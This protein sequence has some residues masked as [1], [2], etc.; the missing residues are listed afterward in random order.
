ME[1]SPLLHALCRPLRLART[2]L[3]AS[4]RKTWT[5]APGLRT[6]RR[7]A[8]YLDG[9][10][11]RV[12]ATHRETSMPYEIARLSDG[13]V[14]HA[15]TIG[16][17][18]ANARLLDGCLYAGRL[19]YVTSDKRPAYL[20]LRGVEARELGVLS[21]SYIG[22]RYFGHWMTDDSTL[23]RAARRI[24]PPIAGVRPS[25]VHREGYER[26]LDL[27][28]DFVERARFDELVVIDDHGM[29]PDRVARLREL[30][31]CFAPYRA[32]QPATGVY[33]RH[34]K[35]GEPRHLQGEAEVEACLARRGF[36]SIEPE[37][38]TPEQVVR[39]LSGASTVV[40]LESS[41]MAPGI[42]ALADGGA[43]LNLLPPERFNNIFKDYLDALEMH[44]GFVVGQP[45]DGGFRLDTGEIERTLDLLDRARAQARAAA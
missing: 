28:R 45:V 27:G 41:A 36:V 8:H 26:I 25:Y 31:A 32:A 7:R 42:L 1:V 11:E 5:I 43:W 38:M 10:L 23:Q 6:R 22:N 4:A 20:D 29:N 2:D 12:I 35:S 39:V 34:G 40:G 16:F 24:G 33:I 21:S 19:R 18:F 14:D 37:S 17:S 30:R 9:Q 15:P 44:Y 3:G 13:F